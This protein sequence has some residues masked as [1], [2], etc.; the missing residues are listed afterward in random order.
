MTRQMLPIGTHG[1]IRR[2][3]TRAG[4]PMADVR[5]RGY[6]GKTR[7]VSRTGKTPAAAENALKQ[8]LAEILRTEDTAMADT[9]LD[10]IIDEWW[11]EWIE[12]TEPPI[13][14]E[15]RYET[16]IRLH[17]RKGLG[18]YTLREARTP[19]INMFL[20]D[21]TK[22][23]GA[24]T[25][26]LAK[27]ILSN[28]MNY[29]LR[30]GAITVNPVHGCAPIKSN[31]TQPKAWTIEE[32][33][34]MRHKLREWDNGTDKRGMPRV[35]DLADPSDFMLG[36][37]CRPG[38]TFAV[39]WPDINFN[40]SPP[41][42]RIHG[43]V[44]KD[45]NYKTVIQD[46]TKGKLDRILAIPPFLVAILL[47]RRMNSLTSLVFPSSTGTVR[48]PDNFR[49]QWQA[50]LGNGIQT[51]NE[52]PKTFRSSVGTFVALEEGADAARAQLGHSTVAVTEKRYI[53]DHTVTR[54]NT[55]TI[56]TIFQKGCY[57]DA[58]GKSDSV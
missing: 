26:M 50:A 37:G 47:R 38:E 7:R 2:T 31:Q 40:T 3:T 29:A 36:T 43:T 34:D 45:K 33:S 27:A 8:H 56:E 5:Y 10:T 19:R 52:L 48:N 22:S 16:V 53:A 9:K 14:T 4:T 23:T 15:R 44:V 12:T 46:H 13:N 17:I 30:M 42:V 21:L 57:E 25:A 18:S 51:F 41:T 35:T 20:R 11:D 39:E 49:L 55:K 28:I 6:D 1:D 24:S 54:D 32:I 58:P